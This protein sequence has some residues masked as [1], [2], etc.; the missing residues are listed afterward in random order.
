M[1]AGGDRIPPAPADGDEADAWLRAALRH[2]PDAEV[3]APHALSAAIL[4]QAVAA[5][6][7]ATTGAIRRPAPPSVLQRLMAAWSWLAQPPVAAGFASVMVA[8]VIGLMW[9]DQPLKEA[10]PA[11]APEMSVVPLPPMATAQ[12]ESEVASKETADSSSRAV[13]KRA[14]APAGAAATP[15]AQSAERRP[16]APGAAL[17]KARPAAPMPVSEP[18]RRESTEALADAAPSLAQAPPTPP[19]PLAAPTPAAA[20]A[21]APAITADA[22]SKLSARPREMG[23][24]APPAPPLLAELRGAIRTEPQRWTWQRGAGVEQPMTAALRAWLDRLGDGNATDN[25]ATASASAS[26]PATELRLLRDGQLHTTLT[27]GVASLR[28]TPADTR[29]APQQSALSPAAATELKTA[30]DAATP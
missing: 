16:V 13:L 5:T 18:A 25:T 7:G 11:R 9:W 2:A 30:L 4:R 17:V 22:V 21:A 19:A 1:S 23:L 12:V 3:G 6:R 15:A 26:V 28:L 24:S 8:G 20:G 29:R 10:L 27:L 14:T